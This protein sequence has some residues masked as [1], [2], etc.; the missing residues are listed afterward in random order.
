[1]ALTSSMLVGSGKAGEDMFGIEGPENWKL[2]QCHPSAPQSQS[3]TFQTH[4][5]TAADLAYGKEE[6]MV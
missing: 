3:A 6:C 2:G 5:L 4:H 1:M